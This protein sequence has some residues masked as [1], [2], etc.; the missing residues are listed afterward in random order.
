[1]STDIRMKDKRIMIT[2][3]TGFLG[4]WLTFTL[5]QIGAI[6]GGF[7]L[8][9]PTNPS[10]FNILNLTDDIAD[11]RGDI[12]D[13]YALNTAI[14]KFDPEV[15]IHLAA[16]PLVL[17]SHKSPINTFQTNIMGTVNALD[18]FSNRGPIRSFISFTSDKVYRNDEKGEPFTEMAALG[19]Y[20]PYSASKSCSDIISASYRNNFI[21]SNEKAISIIRAGNIIGGG[22]WG[23]NRLITDLMK[24]IKFKNK[25]RLRNPYAVRP[26]Q[27]VLDVTHGLTNL[28]SLTLSEPKKYSDDFNIGPYPFYKYSVAELI[29]LFG[30]YWK[31]P[32]IEYVESNFHESILLN[33][34]TEKA[35]N[36]I[37]WRTYLNFSE[38]VRLTSD[39]YK[40]Y[41]DEGDMITFT[42]NQIQHYQ[43]LL[44]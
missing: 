42:A 35:H 29:S 15:I 10:L 5:L 40:E 18:I 27:H 1:M 24:A 3:H 8:D 2:G 30:R 38:S 39:W 12:C 41:F 4:S 7:A 33:L 14:R 17:S 43:D 28:I 23:E 19:G 34:C 25:L 11:F 6:V 32:D 21:N 26:W 9:P 44:E 13:H 37:G 36:L 16:Q 31:L 20:D 22:D